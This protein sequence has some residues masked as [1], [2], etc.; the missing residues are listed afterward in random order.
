MQNT[1]VH[2]EHPSYDNKSF[3]CCNMYYLQDKE[4]LE[5]TS[6]IVGLVQIFHQY[7]FYFIKSTPVDNKD[8]TR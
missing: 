7:C 5:L 3:L 1:R 8:Q 6:E 2:R 4:S